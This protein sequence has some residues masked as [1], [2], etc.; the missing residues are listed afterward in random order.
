MEVL[1]HMRP[2]FVG[3]LPFH[4]PYIG[5]KYMVGTVPELW[6]VILVVF[7]DLGPRDLESKLGLNLRSSHLP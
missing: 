6:P 3:N 7:S 2:Y 1:Y 5:Q 4:R